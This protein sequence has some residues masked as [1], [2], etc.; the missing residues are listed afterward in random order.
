M[1]SFGIES[2]AEAMIIVQK[3]SEGAERREAAAA[4][5]G[6]LKCREAVEALIEALREGQQRLSWMSMTALTQIGSRRHSRKL[7]DTVRGAYLLPARQEALYTLWHLHELRAESLFIRVSSAIDKE[8]EYTRDMATE[9]LGN[10]R[11]HLATQRALSERLFDP[12][13]SVR[14]AA[15]CAVGIVNARTLTCLRRALVAKLTD[16]EKVDDHRVIAELAEHLLRETCASPCR[17]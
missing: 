3:R 15:L 1:R 4:I 8:E 10:T 2:V 12:S 13:V 16:P 9:A 14:Y 17:P 7:M 11:W 5:L 6:E